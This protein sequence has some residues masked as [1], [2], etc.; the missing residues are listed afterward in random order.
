M[1]PP[2]VGKGCRVIRVAVISPESGTASSPTS[3]W[4]SSVLISMFSRRAGSTVEARIAAASDGWLKTYDDGSKVMRTSLASGRALCPCRTPRPTRPS[5]RGPV[6]GNGSCATSS[7]WCASDGARTVPRQHRTDGRRPT[8]QDGRR[9]RY[10]GGAARADV[11]FL[12]VAGRHGPDHPLAVRG[13]FP[14]GNA[15]PG[16]LE[17]KLGCGPPN[18]VSLRRGLSG[19]RALLGTAGSVGTRHASILPQPAP[20]PRPA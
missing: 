19:R 8:P 1:K 5:G 17:V 14:P 18:R 7:S 6:S 16:T 2:C 13:A 4:P 12:G 11:G 15:C 20:R 10:G 3:V 9:R